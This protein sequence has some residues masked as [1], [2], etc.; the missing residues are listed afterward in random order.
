MQANLRILANGQVAHEDSY[1][2]IKGHQTLSLSM[3]AADPG[4]TRFVAQL[5]PSQ[6]HVYQNNELAA[7]TQV[8]GAP[9]VLVVSM[10]AGTAQPGGQAR[11]DEATPFL[12]AMQATGFDLETAQPT[13]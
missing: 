8:L 6:D 11:P 9:K 3:T 7:I 2:L 5:D 12:R 4:F 13:Q 1:R 10:P